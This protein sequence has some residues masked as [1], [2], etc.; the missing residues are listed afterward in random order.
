MG[1]RRLHFYKQRTIFLSK[2]WKNIWASVR[3]LDFCDTGNPDTISFSRFIDNV[4]F[5]R[6]STDIHKFRL[7][8]ISVEDFDRVCGWIGAAVRRN[9]AELNLSVNYYGGD[10]DHPQIFEL[11]Q[12]VFTC[13][14]LRVLQLWSNFI[15]NAPASGCFP[16]LKS[17]YV[18]FDRP[19]NNSMEKLFS[20]CPVLEDL[21]IHGTHGR[22]GDEA[23]LNFTVSAPELKT[24]K[25]RWTTQN[26]YEKCNFLVVT[27][28]LETFHLWQ[29]PSTDCYLENVKSL[30]RVTIALQDHVAD[31]DR[32]FSIRGTALLAVISSVRHLSLSAHCLKGCCLP[33][34]DKLRRLELALYNCY[35]WELLKVLLR[36][37]PRLEYL[38]LELKDFMCP[39]ASSD[40]QW[41]PPDSV[42]ICLLTHLKTVSIWGF[43]GKPDEMDAAKYLLMK[44]LMAE[45]EPKRV[46]D[47]ISAL[48]DA[49][50]CHIPSFLST[51]EAV[52]TYILS[53]RWKKVWASVPNL[54]FDDSNISESV[55]FLRFVDNVLFYRDSTDIQTF[56]LQSSC[57]EDFARIRGWIETAVRRNVV[58]LDIS[59]EDYA[60]DEDHPRV[61]EL[62]ER[63]FRFK[64]LVNLVL[65]SNFIINPPASGCFPS[66]KSLIVYI[67]HPVDKSIEKL[68]SCCPI[69]FLENSETLV[70]VTITLHD[71][72]HDNSA[73]AD[74]HF[75][76]RGTAL[77][78]GIS[79]ARSLYLSAHRLKECCLPTFDKLSRLELILYNC[80]YWELLIQMLKRSPN[81]ENLVL[82][83]NECK[84]GESSDHQWSPPQFVPR[85]LLSQLKTISI[86]GFKSKVDEMKYL[87]ENGEV[88]KKMTIYYNDQLCIQEELHKQLSIFQWGS[89]T[90][91]VEF[92]S[93]IREINSA[94]LGMF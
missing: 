89:E 44:G 22:Y 54:D 66:V 1:I 39:G 13:K 32:L 7:H 35:Y 11:P 37:S 36:R 46:K 86:R 93:D 33:V 65:R 42:P 26:D 5:F 78:A 40:H 16:N 82:E 87:L 74:H 24:L 69:V 90:C 83:L 9:V 3:S 63:V 10:E 25:V 4:L 75:A 60:G 12:S 79:S 43:K 77:L 34:F 85:C 45:L 31:E 71:P 19:V 47:R 68:F 23:V 49:V 73:D 53:K 91:Q 21:S 52:A 56:R 14:T 27:P 20:C 8:S 18:H 55:P 6:D 38:V 15:I 80:Y 30:V 28:K 48:P 41:S 62:P 17:L 64:T 57:I 84:C 70:K 61:L 94:S 81:L 88:L 72:L 92:L 2:R 67:G 58:E 29:Y 51:D 76:I 50:L 59:V